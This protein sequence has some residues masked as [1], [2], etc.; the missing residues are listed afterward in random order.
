MEDVKQ[1]M[2]EMKKLGLKETKIG[3]QL[4]ILQTLFSG[5]GFSRVEL[6]EKTRLSPSTVTSLTAD[7]LKRGIIEESGTKVVT[8]GRARTELAVSNSLGYLVVLEISH[9]C[10]YITLLN[11]RLEIM[12]SR[13]VKG[14]FVDGNS[15]FAAVAQE[16]SDTDGTQPLAGIGI[17][18]QEDV[19]ENS[20]H[21]MYS[22]GYAAA[23]ISLKDAFKTQ[24]RVPVLEESVS[25]FTVTDVIREVGLEERNV[26]HIHLGR[27]IRAVLQIDGSTVVLRDHFVE[28]FSSMLPEREQRSEMSL[29]RQLALLLNVLYAMFHLDTVLIARKQPLPDGFLEELRGGISPRFTQGKMPDIVLVQEGSR[30]RTAIGFAARIRLKCIRSRLEGTV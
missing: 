12:S 8:A 17:L 14:K 7:L 24:F 2:K 25:A 28:D 16:I 18:F 21:V 26:A 11:M 10:I 4:L 23:N 5:N 1:Q 6:A 3:N 13:Q 30:E 19:R 27:Q 9:S 15:V 20:F 29:S 22:T